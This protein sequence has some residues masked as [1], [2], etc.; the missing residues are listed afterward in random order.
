M[1]FKSVL[2]PTLQANAVIA[3]T[4]LSGVAL[5]RLGFLTPP[6]QKSLAKISYW[7]L[8]PAL[9]FSKIASTVDVDQFVSL[10]P[11]P[12]LFLF[13]SVV[14]YFLAI[15]GVRFLRGD[16]QSN[17]FMIA[18]IVFTNTVTMPVP[19]IIALTPMTPILFRHAGSAGEAVA[20]GISMALFFTVFSHIFRWS[21]GYK[22]LDAPAMNE[23]TKEQ[24][25]KGSLTAD[26]HELDSSAVTI[27]MPPSIVNVRSSNVART[28]QHA[29]AVPV[30]AECRPPGIYAAVSSLSLQAVAARRLASLHSSGGLPRVYD[31]KGNTVRRASIGT[32]FPEYVGKDQHVELKP[33]AHEHRRILQGEECAPNRWSDRSSNVTAATP[34]SE[35]IACDDSAAG[36]EHT[37]FDRVRSVITSIIN[38]PF[39]SALVSLC[40]GLIPTLSSVFFTGPVRFVGISLTSI[41]DASIPFQLIQLGGR[42]QR[43]PT[44]DHTTTMPACAIAYVAFCRQVM[45]PCIGLAFLALLKTAGYTPKDPMLA[46]VL[47]LE[48]ST[49]PALNLGVIAE[50]HGKGER[51]MA[52]LLFWTYIVA[53]PGAAFSVVSF[54]LL[55]PNFV[56]PR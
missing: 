3:L 29:P 37:Y 8:T 1:N 2:L 44:R 15:I 24:A 14:S 49:P 45:G 33:M 26:G 9:I 48:A 40:I 23:L 35:C 21:I 27:E 41:G 20:N 50:L 17:R 4:T 34:G 12:A 28:T 56:S 46:F 22:L 13:S 55:L 31:M 43:G 18:A 25:G 5:G 53:I 7:L 38:P 52:N 54:L 32:Y 51:D 30:K 11:I 47:L 6:I 36:K 16:I 10:W 42:L 19:V 39:A